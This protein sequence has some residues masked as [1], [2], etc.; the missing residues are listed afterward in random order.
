MYGVADKIELQTYQHLKMVKS[1]NQVDIDWIA[2]HKQ[3]NPTF[4][5]T[6]IQSLMNMLHE[7]YKFVQHFFM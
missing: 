2:G 7:N 1:L 4:M 5:R 3:S 6:F